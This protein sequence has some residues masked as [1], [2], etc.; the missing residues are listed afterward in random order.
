MISNTP[1]Y[2]DS[3]DN[4]PEQSGKT[5]HIAPYHAK[6]KAEWVDYNGHMSMYC[7]HRVFDDALDAVYDL[8]GVDA[9]YRTGGHSMYVVEAHI[10]Y[11]REAKEGELLRVTTQVLDVDE[12]R[13]HI[14]H[15]MFNDTSGLQLA[16][17]E[18]LLI[19][20]DMGSSRAVPFPENI[21]TGLRKLR[22]TDASLPRPANIGRVIG[23]PS[24]HCV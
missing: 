22:A 9:Q 15:E 13:L 2:S 20:V 5:F 1:A 17:T 21:Y 6:V 12:K 4:Q 19:H 11:A 23:I 8:V 14:F 24:R 7:Y 16:T 3:P 10:N 18:V